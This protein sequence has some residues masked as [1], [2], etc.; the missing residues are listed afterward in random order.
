VLYV[1]VMDEEMIL[2]ALCMHAQAG[3]S[4]RS[5]LS[6]GLSVCRSVCLS[7]SHFL[8]GLNCCKKPF[9]WIWQLSKKWLLTQSLH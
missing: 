3:L 1:A 2:I 8:N 5:C 4:N 7:V 9:S 6:V